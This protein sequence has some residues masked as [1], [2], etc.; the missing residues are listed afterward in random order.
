[1][2]FSDSRLSG[3]DGFGRG[4]GEM[5]E[6]Q[7]RKAGCAPGQGRIRRYVRHL[8]LDA[9]ALGVAPTAHYA[10]V[11]VG[12]RSIRIAGGLL[13]GVGELRDS[14]PSRTEVQARKGGNP[15]SSPIPGILAISSCQ[16]N[17]EL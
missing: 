1:M 2:S 16:L 9:V 13:A 11:S 7:A 14:P 3:R 12:T 15:L 8:D 10:C 17:T 4:G 5:Q 6:T